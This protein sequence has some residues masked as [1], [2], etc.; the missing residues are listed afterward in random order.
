MMFELKNVTRRFGKKLA[1]DSVTLA[2]PQGQMVG[3]IGRSGAGKSTLLR[4]INRLQ[5][6]SS[7][8]VHFA[9]VE[10]SG[11]RGQALRNWQRD[12]AMIF[13]QFNLV[14]RLDV[15]TNVMLGRLNHRSTLMS[16]LN[17]FTREE[18]VHAIAALERLGIEQTALQAA[19]TLSGGQQQRVA[20]A[21]ALMQNPKMVLA[22]EPIASL[23]PLNAK[24]VMDALRDI[25]EREGITV[26]TNLHTL[27]TARNYCERIVGMAGGRVVFDGQPSELTAEAVKEIYGTDKDGAGIDETVTSTS[28]NTAP[29][30]A[31]NQSAGTQPLALAGL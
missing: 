8:S 7:G 27:D 26:I 15:L 16:L 18:R 4:M 24:I 19:G 22:D 12:C 13:Q 30:R 1:V 2:I 28:I 31:D 29:E 6:P 5:E 11:L 3:I 14:P 25:N 9:G 17:I 10:V 20:I 21:R 23:D